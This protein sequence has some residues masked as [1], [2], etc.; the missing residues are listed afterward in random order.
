MYCITVRKYCRD[1]TQRSTCG[2][3]SRSSHESEVSSIKLAPGQTSSR[4]A[5]SQQI[6]CQSWK[7]GDTP[8]CEFDKKKVLAAP[9]SS[10]SDFPKSMFISA[11]GYR[12]VNPISAALTIESSLPTQN[13]HIPITRTP[14]YSM[15]TANSTEDPTAIPWV[16]SGVLCSAPYENLD[17]VVT[18]NAATTRH[19]WDEHKHGQC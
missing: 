15:Y 6:T 2:R 16:K 17:F 10:P 4:Q 12:S 8:F 3:L 14:K 9:T 7:Q 13:A 18:S 1:C 5:T 19:P 11:K